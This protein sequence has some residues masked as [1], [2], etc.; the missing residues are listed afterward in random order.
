[1]ILQTL[2][3]DT[4]TILY[5]IIYSYTVVC[6]STYGIL[7]QYKYCSSIQNRNL[8]LDHDMIVSDNVYCIKLLYQHNHWYRLAVSCTWT[9]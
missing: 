8:Y 1:M 2:L 5:H 9:V 6:D 7:P 4:S 3:V